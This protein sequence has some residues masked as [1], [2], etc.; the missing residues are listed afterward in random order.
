[1]MRRNVW[2]YEHDVDGGFDSST[3]DTAKSIE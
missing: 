3:I 2:V 1:M